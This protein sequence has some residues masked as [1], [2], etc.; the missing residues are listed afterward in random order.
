MMKI[1]CDV[2]RD[3][4]PLVLDEVSSESSKNLVNEHISE[5]EACRNYLAGMAHVL[6]KAK[7]TP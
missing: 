4:M 1:D 5:C 6:P 2:A 7:E 3:L